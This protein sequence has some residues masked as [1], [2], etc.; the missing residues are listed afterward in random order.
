V[1]AINGV[2]S[3]LPATQSSVTGAAETPQQQ[4]EAAL[5]GATGNLTAGETPQQSAEAA[6]V[7][8]SG[9]ATSEVP[10]ELQAGEPPDEVAA[11]ALVSSLVEQIGAEGSTAAN[12][13]SLLSAS[14]TY[15]LTKV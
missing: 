1:S 7:D 15:S 8:L 4:E 14:A 12:A 2:N 11:S 9:G 6:L 10:S 3:N 5:L 13:Y